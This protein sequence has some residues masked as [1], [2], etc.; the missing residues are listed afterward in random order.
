MI[1]CKDCRH[2]IKGNIYPRCA[3]TR[4]TGEYASPFDGGAPREYYQIPD[5]IDAVRQ[6]ERRCG[7][8]AKWFEHKTPWKDFGETV[9]SLLLFGLL[10][11]G[12]IA[13]A[14]FTVWAFIKLVAWSVWYWA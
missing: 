13:V 4:A 8:G 3:R 14:G 6:D 12:V 11:V 10:F 9:L 1:S 5:T 7:R 2:Y